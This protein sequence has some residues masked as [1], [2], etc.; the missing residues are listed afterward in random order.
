[1]ARELGLRRKR[2]SSQQSRGGIDRKNRLHQL[3]NHDPAEGIFWQTSYCTPAA[4][5]EGY[6]ILRERAGKNAAFCLRVCRYF[7]T[8]CRKTR[9]EH[10]Y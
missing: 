5:C 9:A 7:M 8:Q 3:F 1:M 6:A 2:G 4:Q 10:L